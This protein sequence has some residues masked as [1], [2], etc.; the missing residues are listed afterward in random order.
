MT[1]KFYKNGD[2]MSIGTDAKDEDTFLDDCCRV[3]SALID[4]GAH[5]GDWEFQFT[6]WLPQIVELCCKYRGYKSDVTEQRTLFAG[7]YVPPDADLEATADVRGVT[8]ARDMSHWADEDGGQLPPP[9]Q[10][11]VESNGKTAA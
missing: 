8:F 7:S 2:S 9:A 6:Y 4:N 1:T 10:T 5:G 11:P 3:L